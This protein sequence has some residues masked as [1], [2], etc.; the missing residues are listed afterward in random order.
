[1]MKRKFITE[2]SCSW[3]LVLSLLIVTLSCSV[4]RDR[5]MT[6]NG[7]LDANEMGVTLT[8]E[9][10][11]VD[12]IGADSTG[13]HRWDKDSVIL[14][15]LPY[16]EEIKKYGCKTFI[17]CTPAYVGRDPVILRVLSEKTGLNILTTTGYYGAHNNNFIPAQALTMTADQLADIWLEEWNEG[18]EDTGIRPGIIK[19]AVQGEVPLSAFHQTIVRAA[20]IT[21]LGSGLTI[22]SHTGP[23]GP[24]FEQ[25]E[26]L[27]EEGISPDA[28]V[29]THAQRGSME[30]HIKAAEMG[31]WISLDNV[32]D[33]EDNISSYIDMLM[34]LKN[35]GYL[36]RVLLSHDSGWYNVGQ[37][38]GGNFRPYTAIFTHLLAAMRKAGFT[39]DEIT[40]IMEK[41]PQKAYSIKIRKT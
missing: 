38:G 26:I 4:K 20:A 27:K 37:P 36:N 5:I 18:I 21:H 8:H 7:W 39:D 14:R 17:E 13:Y 11:I 25:L 28:F 24:A 33:A 3:L 32:R 10:V 41:N 9:H 34:N 19:I 23:G 12:F 35:H 22:V 6:V 2:N 40:L 29:W 31:A 30:D 16:L 15:A 1:M